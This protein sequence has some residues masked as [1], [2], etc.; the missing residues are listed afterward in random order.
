MGTEI[1]KRMD[2][3]SWTRSLTETLGQSEKFWLKQ[4]A[5]GGATAG[6]LWLYKPVTV[7]ENDTR[8]IGDWCEYAV[9]QVAQSLNIQSAE[10]SLV[11]RDGRDGCLSRNV[12]PD[13]S[14]AMITGRRWLDAD[15][16]VSYSSAAARLSRRRSGASPGHSLEN[17][18]VSLDGVVAPPGYPDGLT[19]WDVFCAYLVLDAVVGN[20]D[21]HEENWSIMRPLRGADALAPAYD[22]ESSLGFQ[23]QDEKRQTILDD[24]SDGSLLRYAQR[25]TAW[26]FEGHKKTPLVEVAASSMAFCSPRGRSWVSGLV[27]RA[28]ELDFVRLLQPVDGMSAVALRFSL[29]LLK[30][31]VRRLEDAFSNSRSAGS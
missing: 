16:D 17:I 15:P 20:R 8:Q 24:V 11:T 26:R 2:V 18:R 7:H 9:W 6:E 21:R 22:M 4:P 19:A 14:W 28:S 5:D 12:R 29:M 27:A 1:V 23:L 3:S 25:G 10:I 31:N 13:G 30:T